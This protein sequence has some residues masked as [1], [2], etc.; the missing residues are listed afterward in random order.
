MPETKIISALR[1]IAPDYD[2]LLC[3]AW[4]VVHNGVELFDGVEEALSEF[5]AKHGPVFILTNAPRLSS[6]IPDQLDSLGLSRDAYDGV[7]TS[8]D[9]TLAAVR[10][11]EGKSAFKLGPDKDNTIFD[12]FG[13]DFVEL[14]DA[15][16]IL[17][18]GLFDDATETPE[19]YHELLGKA[20][21][22]NLPFVCA[23]P[24]IVVRRGKDLIYCGGALAEVYEKLG[25]NVIMAGKPHAPIYELAYKRLAEVRYGE[26]P[27]RILVIGDGF[28]TDILGA[29]RQHLD[30][31]FIADGISQDIGRNDQ[32]RLDGQLVGDLLDQRGLTATAAMEALK[33]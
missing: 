32:G 27:K 16:F 19:D 2:A 4:G 25:G 11:F 17:C 18:T 33:W 5:R 20:H 21:A 28:N 7:V 22:L 31:V 3:D 6:V 8:G 12:A 26:K 1:E 14:E 23:N 13:I 10:S 30:V 24:D 9:A 15:A 29:N